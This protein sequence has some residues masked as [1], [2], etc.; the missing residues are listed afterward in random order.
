MEG[1]GGGGADEVL[2]G[3]GSIDD[4]ETVDTEGGGG[5]L[6]VSDGGLDSLGIITEV[7]GK[8]TLVLSTDTDGSGTYSDDINILL[9]GGGVDTGGGG[10]DDGGTDDGGMDDGGKDDGGK[11]DDGGTDDDTTP[12]GRKDDEEE[13]SIDGVLGVGALNV[14]DGSEDINDT[15]DTGALPNDRGTS[16]DTSTDIDGISIGFSEH[17]DED[18]TTLLGRTD[19]KL[20]DENE[21]SSEGVLGDGALKS[22]GL[23]HGSPMLHKNEMSTNEENDVTDIG[24]KDTD[25]GSGIISLAENTQ[26]DMSL[27]KLGTTS[28]GG[29]EQYS[30][31]SINGSDGAE[32]RK[33]LLGVPASLLLLRTGDGAE[34]S[35]AEHCSTDVIENTGSE[36]T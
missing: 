35:S 34:N 6:N 11:D 33:I 10:T 4:E 1:V 28:V 3:G 19:G 18:T 27:L 29:A 22:S 14:S 21:L 32:G 30:T 8:N 23:E 31:E 17:S 25:G 9:L 5:A 12:G 13:H 2:I 20:E 15:V 36:N 7:E 16:S 26:L 24:G